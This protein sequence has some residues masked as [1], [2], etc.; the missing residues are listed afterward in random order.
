MSVRLYGTEATP[1]EV[2]ALTTGAPPF[3]KDVTH[4]LA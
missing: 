4:L 1:R 2:G 3:H